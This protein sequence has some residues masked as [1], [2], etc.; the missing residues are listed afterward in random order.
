MSARAIAKLYASLIG[1]VDGVRLIPASRLEIATT[2]VNKPGAAP[3]CFGHGFGLG[4]CL[5]GPASYPGEFFGHGGAGGSEGMGNKRL[6]L[7]VGLT[8]NRM[9]THY[10]APDHTNRLLMRLI[11]DT[12]GEPIDG[13]F[14]K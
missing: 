9:D 11:A 2:P 1:E 5:K 4:W 8:K 13:G 10:A 3:I 6:K 12:L 14:Y 7:A